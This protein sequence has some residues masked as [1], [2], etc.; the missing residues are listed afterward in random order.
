MR[1]IRERLE[2][3][4]EAIQLIE[5]ETSGGREAFVNDRKLQVWVI[6]HVQII[7]EAIKPALHHLRTQAPEIPWDQVVG[8]RNILVHDYFGIDLDEVWSVVEK[9]LQPLKMAVERVLDSL[10]R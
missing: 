9:D 3:V 6:H 10:P 4:L 1:P 7:G 5:E 8:M 2:D